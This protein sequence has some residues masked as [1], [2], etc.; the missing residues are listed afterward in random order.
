MFRNLGPTIGKKLLFNEVIKL[1][2]TKQDFI[3]GQILE[4]SHL[5]NIEKG[6]E[7]NDAAIGALQEEVSILKE[8]GGT[9][10][11]SPTVEVEKTT[12]GTLITI[13]DVNGTKTATI[14][15]GVGVSKVD[16]ITTSL[17]DGG[18]NVVKIELTDGTF[19]TV[20]IRNGNAG[21]GIKSALLN[22]DYTLTLTF[23]DDTSYTTPSIRGE[24]PIKG[25]D[26]FTNADKEELVAQ[27]KASLP[28]I[29]MIG[30]D[31]DGVSHTFT[32]YGE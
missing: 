18:T 3:D 32:L 22:D 13:T 2:Y 8:S 12:E 15:D 9:S 14:K 28:T 20:Q 21:N 16:Q 4:A 23:D 17:A 7:N 6:I 25:E 10:G 29:T 24:T 1:S 26:Y 11:F 27:V 31:A 19:T 30:I 5:N